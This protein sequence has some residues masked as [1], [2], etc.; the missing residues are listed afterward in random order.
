MH[1]RQFSFVCLSINQHIPRRTGD[2]KILNY[3]GNAPTEEGT[4]IGYLFVLQL[5]I[6]QYLH[7]SLLRVLDGLCL[8]AEEGVHLRLSLVVFGNTDFK[9]LDALFGDF[10]L[11]CGFQVREK[12]VA[13]F[14]KLG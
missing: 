11:K 10:F 9:Y 8:A 13:T 6:C 1:T 3:A 14:S 4:F 12:K 7:R 5:K 2:R